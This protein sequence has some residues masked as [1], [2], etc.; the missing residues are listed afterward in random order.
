MQKFLILDS[1]DNVAVATE[2][3][4]AGTIIQLTDGKEITIK[5]LIPFAHKFS[6]AD[7]TAGDSIFKYGE[8]IGIATA[9]VKTGEHVHVHNIKGVHM[10]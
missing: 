8:I 5:D 10:G 4:E 7:L 6:L 2:L 1:K 9:S 3:I